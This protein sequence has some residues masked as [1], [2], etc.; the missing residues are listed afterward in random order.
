MAVLPIIKLG[1]PSLRKRAEEVTEFNDELK[2]LASN[3]IETMRVNDG[4]GLAGPQV[5]VLK[6]I[7]VIDLE[8]IDENLEPRAYVNPRILS[9]SGSEVMEEGCLSIPG[10]R[11]DVTRSAEIEV[12]YQTLEGEVIQ[13]TLDDLTARVFLHEYDHLN[14]VLFIDHISPLQRKLLAPKLKK[15]EESH[16]LV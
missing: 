1:H 5:N 11:A 2:E 10:V 16:S 13:E 14:G 9:E 8:Q 3:M 7:F 4:I 12:E 6:R 15:I